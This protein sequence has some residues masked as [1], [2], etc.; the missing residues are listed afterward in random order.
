MLYAFPNDNAQKTGAI[1][2]P[3]DTPPT[4]AQSHP[5]RTRRGLPPEDDSLDSDII[6]H[7]LAA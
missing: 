3:S 1:G 6:P 5:F 7:N 4:D 2:L